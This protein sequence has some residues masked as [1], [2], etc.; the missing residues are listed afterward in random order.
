VI[1]ESYVNAEKI[2][3]FITD[4]YNIKYLPEQNTYNDQMFVMDYT[5]NVA[6]PF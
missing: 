5:N 4:G 6:T 3:Q 1:F 2:N